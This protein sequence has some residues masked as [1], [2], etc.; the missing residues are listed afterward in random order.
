MS[1]ALPHN[2]EA[3]TSVLG[4]CLIEN[5][6]IA[7]ARETVLPPMFFRK[8]HE[9]IWSAMNDLDRKNIPV[10]LP[11][12]KDELQRREQLDEVGGPA[13]LASLVDGVPRST[14]VDYYGSIVKDY[15]LRRSIIFAGNQLVEDGYASTDETVD[16]LIDKAEHTLLNLSRARLQSDGYIS[17]ENWMVGTMQQIRQ[18]MEHKSAV[19]GVPSGFPRIDFLTRGFQ[20]GNLIIL[21]GR[22]SMGKT[23]LALQLAREGSRHGTIGVLS[24]EMSKNELGMRAVSLEAKVDLHRILTG[25]LDEKAGKAVM[26]AGD[27]IEQSGLRIDESPEVTAEQVRSRAKRLASSEPLNMLVIDYLQLMD[28]RQQKGEN[29][30]QAIART[31]RKIKGIAKELHVPIILLSQLSRANESRQDKRPMLSDLRESGAIE[32]DADV[33]LFI[34]RPEYYDKE[35][36]E[37]LAELIIAKQRNGPVATVELYFEKRQTRFYPYSHRPGGPGQV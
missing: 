11:I 36:P 21:A 29:R 27:A 20:P 12:L 22:P 9:L 16:L 17:A 19:T 35:Q 14:N 6:M 34:H 28:T 4:G 15:W 24:I 31:T 13:Y 8:A 25:D 1:R 18:L 3:E 5:A 7:V 32:Q 10:D 23:S 26:D 2:L 33:V 37:G 30:E